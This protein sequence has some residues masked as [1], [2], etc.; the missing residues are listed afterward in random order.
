M[1]LK[2]LPP[3]IQEKPLF[4]WQLFSKS[5]QSL[6]EIVYYSLDELLGKGIM[7]A[8]SFALVTPAGVIAREDA[9]LIR[10][11]TPGGQI[12]LLP[13]HCA[14]VGLVMRE[15]LKLSLVHQVSP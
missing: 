2:N 15:I 6:L 1:G 5:C 12:E 3:S 9:S 10:A 13:G 14:Y 7:N 8:L 4:C 11:I